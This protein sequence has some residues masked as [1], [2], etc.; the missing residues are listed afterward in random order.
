MS[1]LKGADTRNTPKRVPKHQWW[2]SVQRNPNWTSSP[3]EESAKALTHNDPEERLPSPQPTLRDRLPVSLPERNSTNV[4]GWYQKE[5]RERT[6][7]NPKPEPKHQI[8]CHQTAGVWIVQP[9]PA[10]REILQE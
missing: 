7:R 5:V 10:E 2:L 4:H 1:K 6:G 9:R 3:E 8:E